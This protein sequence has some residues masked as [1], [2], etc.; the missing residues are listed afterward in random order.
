MCVY[1]KNRF[2]KLNAVIAECEVKGSQRLAVKGF[3]V[4]S[5][6]ENC[7]WLHKL[8]LR[9]FLRPNH[10]ISKK[11]SLWLLELTHSPRN[12]SHYI[13][14]SSWNQ[15]Q[16]RTCILKQFPRLVNNW[17]QAKVCSDGKTSCFITLA[18][19]TQTGSVNICFEKKEQHSTT[20]TDLFLSLLVMFSCSTAFGN[21]KLKK[22][23]YQFIPGTPW[24]LQ[25]VPMFQWLSQTQLHLRHQWSRHS[26][27]IILK[28]IQ[29]IQII[30][31]AHL[32]RAPASS[33]NSIF[34]EL[35]DR[36]LTGDVPTDL[37]GLPVPFVKS[38]RVDSWILCWGAQFLKSRQTKKLRFYWPNI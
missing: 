23:V 25:V 9:G 22:R 37:G 17:L 24:T 3:K 7:H 6:W 12:T 18:S 4:P 11:S 1:V 27:F 35:L 34:N 8:N 20:K 14:I 38:P 2:R 16:I 29:S 30:C 36:N 5:W 21:L 13:T 33:K 19:S 10:K 28:S 15:V 26:W 32:T 31:E